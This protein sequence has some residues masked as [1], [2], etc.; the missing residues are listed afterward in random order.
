[1]A[2]YKA[3]YISGDPNDV[4]KSFYI[5]FEL[6]RDGVLLEK[7]I[8]ASQGSGFVGSYTYKKEAKE[9]YIES[10]SYFYNGFGE[11]G[12]M[13][14]LLLPVKY[15]LPVNDIEKNVKINIE[16]YTFPPSPTPPAAPAAK[17]TGEIKKFIDIVNSEL[18]TV[19]SALESKKTEIKKVYDEAIKITSLKTTK[20]PLLPPQYKESD[21]NIKTIGDLFKYTLLL[22]SL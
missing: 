20:W 19:I 11:W 16:G 14:T 2:N 5:T 13:G 10:N 18:N 3:K 8:D 17:P 7:F 12:N 9:I 4:S 21:P 1:M 15:N 6:Y 22:P